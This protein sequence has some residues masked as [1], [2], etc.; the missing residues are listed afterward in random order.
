MLYKSIVTAVLAVGVNALPNKVVARQG[1]TAIISPSVPSPVGCTANY[2][3]SFGIAVLAITAGAPAPTYAA[4]QIPDG[5]AQVS[6]TA[7]V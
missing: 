2:V 3:G 6:T 4:A 7:P 5:Q 1:V